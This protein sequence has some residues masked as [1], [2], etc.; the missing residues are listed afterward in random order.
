MTNACLIIIGNEVLSGR[1]QDLNLAFLGKRLNKIGIRIAEARVIA[2]DSETII[3]TLNECRAKYDHVFTTG[4]IGPTH[5]D[6]TSAAVAKAFDLPLIRHP[7][8]VALL[9]QHYANPEDLNEQRLKM[10]EVP[11]GAILVDNPISK[12]PG[13][14]IGN[15]F[16]LA[17]VPRIMQAM[18]E[19]LKERLTPGE[20]MNSRTI[21]AFMGEGSLAKGLGDVQDTHSE[22]EIG[23]YPFIRDGKLGTALVL[24]GANQKALNGAT[25]AVIDL[26]SGFDIEYFEETSVE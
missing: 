22:I 12:A 9:R 1:T 25:E 16:V 11:R 23:S 14:Q 2:D 24:R 10:C 5:D 20:P 18:Y 4:G 13:Y 7:R 8:A 17:G 19:A 6:I 21:V 26:V 15:V 3:N